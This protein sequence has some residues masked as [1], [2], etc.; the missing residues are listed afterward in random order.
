MIRS[1][2]VNIPFSYHILISLAPTVKGLHYLKWQI[3]KMPFIVPQSFMECKNLTVRGLWVQIYYSG[4]NY[5]L[6]YSCIYF[7]S[8]SS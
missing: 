1:C 5:D 2:N 6:C 8:T 3:S 4:V 7:T